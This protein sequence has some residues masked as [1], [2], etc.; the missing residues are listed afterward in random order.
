MTCDVGNPVPDLVQ[1]QGRGG[2]KP[3]NGIPTLPS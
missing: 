1:A 3:V 2:I